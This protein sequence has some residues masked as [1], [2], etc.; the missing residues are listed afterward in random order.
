[1]QFSKLHQGSKWAN[2]LLSF[3]VHNTIYVV[4]ISCIY[5]QCILILYIYILYIYIIYIYY[6]HNMNKLQ[7]NGT[8]YS[9]ILILLLNKILKNFILYITYTYIYILIY[10][11]ICW[12]EIQKTCPGRNSRP[13]SGGY[14]NE[15]LGRYFQ[16]LFLLKSPNGFKIQQKCTYKRRK[17]VYSMSQHKTFTKNTRN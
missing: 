2:L 12:L 6:L 1:M 13:A 16:G 11:Y 7:N 10:I 4:Y 8:S 5:M 9:N 3:Y 14:C 15:L 17:N